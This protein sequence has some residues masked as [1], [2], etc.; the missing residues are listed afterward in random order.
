MV[1]PWKHDDDCIMTQSTSNYTINLIP[2]H[3]DVY[4]IQL[5]ALHLYQL[6]GAVNIHIYY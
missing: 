3:S 5:H 1:Q 2:T 6:I 4:S